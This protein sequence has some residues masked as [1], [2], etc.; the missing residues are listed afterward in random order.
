MS[1]N[2]SHRDVF[3]VVTIATVGVLIIGLVFG[4]LQWQMYAGEVKQPVLAAP[5]PKTPGQPRAVTT[6]PPAVSTDVETSPATAESTEP[7]AAGTNEP[8]ATT[9]G[10]GTP[11]LP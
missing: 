5:T 7:A 3:T 9:P 10:G 1:E 2:S 6:Q 11:E 8:A 4:V